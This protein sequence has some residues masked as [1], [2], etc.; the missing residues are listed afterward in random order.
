MASGYEVV[1]YKAD[2]RSQVLELQSHLWSPSLTLNE[3]YF[4]WKFERN[5]YQEKPLIYLAMLD[6]KAVGMR[7]CFG[8]KWEV[9]AHGQ[10]FI[11]FCADDAVIAPSHRNRGVMARIMSAVLADLANSSSVDYVFNLSAAPMT[12]L[13]SIS[14]GWRSAGYVQPMHWR[15]PLVSGGIDALRAR[16]FP[17]RHRTF[18]DRNED[19]AEPAFTVVP[20]IS[21]RGAARCEEMAGLVKRI[22]D[23]GRIRHVRDRE[24]FDWRFQNPLSRYRFLFYDTDC[25]E[26]Y[27][28]LQEYTSDFARDATVNIV[29]W[30]ASNSAIKSELLQAALKFVRDRRVNIW[31]ATL[32]PEVRE[33]LIQNHF[34][35]ETPKPPMLQQCPGILVRS[36]RDQKESEW[37]LGDLRLTELANWDLRMLFSMRG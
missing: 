7:S 3:A 13:T 11:G 16:L 18:D 15:P 23:P 22:G 14:T 27:L 29:D 6:G 24:Y 32:P 17:K 36:I 34:Q 21:F 10:T 28:V 2:L 30:E 20:E 26:G 12:F 33:L 9:G 31:S 25:L 8:M 35:F 1:R 5:P 19:Q 4:E 37:M